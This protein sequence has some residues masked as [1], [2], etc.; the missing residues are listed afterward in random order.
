MFSLL[1]WQRALA[2]LFIFSLTPNAT[3]IED[4]LF[5][6]SVT[7]CN[8]P[9][10]LL[11]QRFELAY[12]P[13][14]TSV[15]F[16][17]SAASVQANVNV[18]ANLF[19]NVY[20]MNPINVTLDLCGILKGA[21]CPLPMYN[22][23]GADSLTLPSSLSVLNKIPK[24]AYK[25]PD[26]EG[27]AQ[28]T[29]TE[30]KTGTVKACVQATLSNGRS[31]HQPAVEWT[32]GGVTLAALLFA[33]WQSIYSP[34]AILPFRLLEL[35]YLFQSIASSS[36]LNLNYPSVYRAFA[37]NFAWAM[38][39][40]SSGPESSL[41]NSIN[42]MRHLTGGNLADAID[43]S[44]V[45]LVNRKLSPYN[46]P[47]SSFVIGTSFGSILSS[48]DL[49]SGFTGN[50][51]RLV[52]ANSTPHT[53]L[54]AQSRDTIVNGNVQTVTAASS[55]VLQA[56]IPIY[57]NT[58]HIATANAFMT[59]FLVGLCLL[60]IALAVFALGYGV[61]F[62]L[63]R[64]Q[65]RRHNNRAAIN[66][67]YPSFAMSW[68]LRLALVA[69]FPL[70][71]FI[72][73]Q[74]TLKDSWLSIFIS[75]LTLI[76][77]TCSMAYPSF[78]TLRFA[79]RETPQDLYAEN[80]QILSQFGPLYA[81]YRSPRYYFFVPL[82]VAFFLRAIFI[83]FAKSSAEAQIAL[84][85]MVELGL[86]LA[87]FVLKPAKTRGGDV[88]GTYLAIMRLV[89]TSLMV[90]FIQKVEVKAIPRVV[91]GI[92]IALVWSVAVVI[93]IGNL[94]WHAFSA[95]LSRVRSRKETSSI[96]GSGV[97]SEGSMM[98][99][100]VRR[101]Q[102]GS[103]RSDLVEKD[104]SRAARSEYSLRRDDSIGGEGSIEEVARARPLNPTPEHNIPLDP[105]LLTPYPISPTGTTVS[106]MDPP[107]LYSRD[108]GTMT[109]GS[110]LPRRWS[111]SLSQPGS[112]AG[113]SFG[114]GNQCHAASLTSSPFP[115][116]SPSEGSHSNGSQGSHGSHSA[117]SRN[118]SVRAAQQQ[119]QQRHADIEEEEDVEGLP[120]SKTVRPS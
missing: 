70:L 120:A 59:V 86:V 80:S 13:A 25:I 95:I 32:T 11:I 42:R 99:K 3:A 85:I 36:F 35:M 15:S 10:T 38:G 52:I 100:G 48:R 51:S 24:I 110:L 56:G 76:A 65:T 20:G 98:E 67:D 66:F 34:E 71:I 6:S 39:L 5:T 93:V 96:S 43:S 9:E 103:T 21:L 91:I 83:S 84:L 79:R 57:V 33:A 18:T 90:A 44:A 46:S 105:Y 115:P 17:V 16:N 55:N 81:Q 107:S 23:T 49:D 87:H 89:S 69:A 37:L 62:L 73:Y 7:Y 40:L 104:A 94:A 88:F 30:V 53:A 29:L 58:K 109:V 101:T 50:L 26:L 41:Q 74:W 108:S 22:F 114:H 117:L 31:A 113:S 112:P 72:F 19:L 111:F 118:A 102:N 54:S 75:V 4:I 82:L 63:E 47:S 97:G 1:A 12:F 8:P 2:I 68:L 60:A 45:G 28:L 106:T 77:I 119:H 78:I 27:F 64:R 61:M 116:S 92:V 14:N